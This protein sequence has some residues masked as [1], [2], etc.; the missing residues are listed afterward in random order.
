VLDIDP[1]E[2]RRLTCSLVV[3]IPNECV[4]GQSPGCKEGELVANIETNS[5]FVEYI[6]SRAFQG[7][8]SDIACIDLRDIKILLP[9]EEG[10][11]ATALLEYLAPGIPTNMSQL[12][13]LR[14]GILLKPIYSSRYV[15]VKEHLQ[16]V[17][18][19]GTGEVVAGNQIVE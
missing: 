4:G 17:L 2:I 7:V 12:V 10:F 3:S 13:A 15:F 19:L 16:P 14:V 1:N 8:G 9:Q 6:R 18:Y 5:I 11:S